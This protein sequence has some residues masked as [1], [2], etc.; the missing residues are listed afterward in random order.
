MNRVKYFC[1]KI[2]LTLANRRANIAKNRMDKV[3]FS[4]RAKKE[5]IDCTYEVF[6]KR[7]R[8]QEKAAIM[9]KRAKNEIPGKPFLPVDLGI[10][11]YTVLPKAAEK[12]TRHDVE[13]AVTRHRYGDWGAVSDRH[14]M[15]NNAG[16]KD[17]CG[18]IRSRYPLFGGGYFRVETDQRARTTKLYLDGEA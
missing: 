9:L 10:E 5:E 16:V 1:A 7:C 13:V 18:I 17:P 12:L 2:R 4:S 14:W 6:L 11:Q 15:N 3:I 8:Q